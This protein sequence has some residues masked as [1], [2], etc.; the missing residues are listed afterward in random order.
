MM[1][2]DKVIFLSILIVVLISFAKATASGNG[3]ALTKTTYAPN[4]IVEGF[5]N[6]SLSKEPADSPVSAL[7]QNI[8]LLDFLKKNNL[9]PEK[10]F[11]CNPANCQ[12]DYEIESGRITQKTLS[13]GENII[14]VKITGSNLEIRSDPLRFTIQG[15][16]GNSLCGESPLEIDLLSDKKAE[17]IYLEPSGLCSS[18]RPG[19]CYNDTAAVEDLD[20]MTIPYCQKIF[21]PESGR[22]KL[23]ALVK[24]NRG[25]GDL[26]AFIY[27]KKTGSSTE[28]DLDEPNVTSYIEENCMV[29]LPVLQDAQD[30]YLCIKDNSADNAYSI[31]GETSAPLCGYSGISNIGRNASADFAL[32]AQQTAIAPFNITKT[33]NEQEFGKFSS[34]GVDRYIQ[35]YIKSRYA[36]DCRDGCIIPIRIVSRNG[37]IITDLSLGYCEQ[38]L[39]KTE[40]NF[41]DVTR[42]PATIDINMTQLDLRAANFSVGSYGSYT[43]KLS[44][45]GTQVGEEEFSVE[46]VPMI[47]NIIS[48]NPEA[49]TEMNFFADAYS[50]KNNSIVSFEWSFGDGSKAITAVN[51]AN[52]TY[53][54]VGRF[55]LNIK[56]TDSEGLTGSRTFIIQVGSPK[57]ILNVTLKNKRALLE[58]VKTKIG[59]EGWYKTLLEKQLKISEYEISLEEYENEFRLA[60][61]D[62]EYVTLMSKLDALVLPQMLYDSEFVTEMPIAVNVDDIKPEYIEELGGGIYDTELAT[63]TK[64]AIW[65]WQSKNLA[66]T[67]N[68]R[69]MSMIDEKNKKQDVAT[70]IGIKLKANTALNEVYVAILAPFDGAVF[71]GQYGQRKIL[72]GIG[73]V[74]ANLSNQVLSVALPGKVDIAQLVL[75]ASPYLS[76]LEIETE[77]ITCNSNGVCEKELG[78]TWKNCREDCKPVGLAVFFLVVVLGFVALLYILLQ[79]WYKTKYESY[80]FKNPQDMQNIILFAKNSLNKGGSEKEVRG[81]LKD[82]GW[83][84]EQI[85]Y[86]FKKIKGEKTGMPEIKFKLPKRKV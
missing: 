83:G 3:M 8:S 37:A 74:F 60:T 67:A 34:T 5:I 16:N 13:S 72:E 1:F 55:N 15:S 61:T 65:G 26:A 45:G 70:I 66:V 51:Y 78:E 86:I 79:K 56:V 75:F 23:A 49:G 73:F 2:K 19:Y 6:V 52:H 38:G 43:F 35:D 58:G 27:D 62:A 76:D 42:K 85:D 21:L 64:N 50:P 53:S 12:D 44:I 7:G 63:E 40:Q 48:M 57:N 9:E 41:F 46:K 80:L 14:G 47:R 11:Y 36:N 68:S 81:K 25:G 17:W 24:K 82:A 33:F 54:G 22:F 29:D 39:C 30:Y 71:G 28:C 84:S 77:K 32:F 4:D 59:S 10:D 69:I 18:L 20:V 31:K